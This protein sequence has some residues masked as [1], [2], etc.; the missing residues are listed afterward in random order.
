MELPTIII[1]TFCVLAASIIKGYTLANKLIAA[2]FD[3]YYAVRFWAEYESKYGLWDILS[4]W[5]APCILAVFSFQWWG[6]LYLPIIWLAIP[7]LSMPFLI[8]SLKFRA[9]ETKSNIKNITGKNTTHADEV[10]VMIDKDMENALT[11]LIEHP[12]IAQHFALSIDDGKANSRFRLAFEIGLATQ[13][14]KS[15][16]DTVITV[17]TIDKARVFDRNNPMSGQNRFN[18]TV[19]NSKHDTKDISNRKDHKKQKKNAHEVP[20]EIWK[21]S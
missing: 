11:W 20:E 13:D 5:V 12:K 2:L 15:N 21:E 6:L 9:N 16:V 19:L 18:P 4:F 8:S 14:K 3:E 7:Y 1:C 17:S 10:M